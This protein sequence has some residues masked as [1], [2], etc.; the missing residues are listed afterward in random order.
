MSKWTVL[1]KMLEDHRKKD[2]KTNN[3]EDE[4]I[5]QWMT[6]SEP[7]KEKNILDTLKDRCE[8]FLLT[9]IKLCLHNIFDI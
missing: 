5:S 2:I 9:Y 1:E 8:F 7:A 3:T 6:V 4:L